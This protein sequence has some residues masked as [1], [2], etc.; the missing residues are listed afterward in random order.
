MS[1]AVR[2]IG[3]DGVDNV[4]SCDFTN[5]AAPE[6]G[7]IDV[8]GQIDG[9]G[10][11]KPQ[12]GPVGQ[13]AVAF[14]DIVSRSVD[15]G[16][17]QYGSGQSDLANRRGA[18]I[19]DIE[20]SFGVE[21]QACRPVKSTRPARPVRNY[22]Y[23]RECR[24]RRWWKQFRWYS[25]SARVHLWY[26]RYTGC[27]WHPPP[28]RECS[29]TGPYTRDR[30]RPRIPAVCRFRRPGVD[31]SGC[32]RDRADEVV[33]VVHEI[34]IALGI[35]SVRQRGPFISK[36]AWPDHRRRRGLRR[37]G[38]FPQWWKPHTAARAP[39]RRRSTIRRL[40]GNFSLIPGPFNVPT[41]RWWHWSGSKRHRR[42]WPHWSTT[43]TAF[44]GRRPHWYLHVHLRQPGNFSRRAARVCHNGGQTTDGRGNGKL[45]VCRRERNKRAVLAR[46][47]RL[48]LTRPVYG[49][50]TAALREPA[51][52]GHSGYRL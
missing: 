23:R 34:D 1:A 31:D 24:F 43:G 48:S 22:L 20:I 11:G 2:N 13:A 6:V 32:G 8:A 10:N 30:H 39:V 29:R 44:P 27:L 3:D 40:N 19:G 49:D 21:G 35:G 12:R 25:P 17:G 28:S 52:S 42:S 18:E 9:N 36:R 15:A 14:E 33:V 47:R 7:D 37:V 45:R 16:D 38:E 26:R 46:G 4:V 51:R 5:A 41:P 50:D